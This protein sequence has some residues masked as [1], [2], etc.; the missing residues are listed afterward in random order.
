MRIYYIVKHTYYDTSIYWEAHKRGV[1]SI[2]NKFNS[3]NYVDNTVSYKSPDD[4]EALLR[5]QLHP[6]EPVVIRTI[7]I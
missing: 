2:F 6:I 5:Y 4:C 3:M 1:Y 7:M